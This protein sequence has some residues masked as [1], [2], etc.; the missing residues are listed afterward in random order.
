MTNQGQ[1]N[2]NREETTPGNAITRGQW[3][4][5]DYPM[6][7]SIFDKASN[8][9]FEKRITNSNA[10][11]TQEYNKVLLDMSA[12]HGTP[13]GTHCV[14]ESHHHGYA[15]GVQIKNGLFVPKPTVDAVFTAACHSYDTTRQEVLEGRDG[16]D[17]I[18]IERFEWDIT[19]QALKVTLGS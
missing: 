15:Y 5:Q 14:Y 4:D 16:I 3:H 9:E 13:D 10:N 2:P 8:A 11:W 1:S 17:H 12:P 6:V 19:L 18:Y 7:W